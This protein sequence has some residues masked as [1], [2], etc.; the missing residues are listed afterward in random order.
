[1]RRAAKVDANQG[2]IVDA[3]RRIGAM[4][5]SL[6]QLGKGVPD[7]LVAFRGKW[8][9]AEIKDGSKPPSAQK[10][11]KD[12]AEWHAKFNQAAK[13]CVW[14]STEEALREVMQ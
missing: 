13:V 8:W 6:A 3:L 2:E 1:M 9:V 14:K 10:L 4:V 11:T 7:I 12:E 5:Q